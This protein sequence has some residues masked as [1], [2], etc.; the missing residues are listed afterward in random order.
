MWLPSVVQQPTRNYTVDSRLA[1]C[2][3]EIR[4]LISELFLSISND[5]SG[6]TDQN[7]VL[8]VLTTTV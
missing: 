8:N 1:T 2:W 5:T 6:V 4:F 3:S 7:R